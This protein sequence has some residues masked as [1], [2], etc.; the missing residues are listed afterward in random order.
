MAQT[1]PSAVADWQLPTIRGFAEGLSAQRRYV[2]G[3]SYQSSYEHIARELGMPCATDLEIADAIELCG[4]FDCPECDRF[5]PCPIAAERQDA[6]FWCRSGRPWIPPEHRPIAVSTAATAGNQPPAKEQRQSRQPIHR[7][8]RPKKEPTISKQIDR[9]RAA[10]KQHFGLA[11]E[12]DGIR[13]ELLVCLRRLVDELE[14]A[15]GL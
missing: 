9:L 1:S 5:M 14:E 7:Q 6:C 3:V 12:I 15:I 8:P 4:L 11:A 10:E 13:R 2:S